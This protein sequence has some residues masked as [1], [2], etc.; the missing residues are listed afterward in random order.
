[1][2][3]SRKIEVNC[4]HCEAVGTYELHESINANLH[5]N[6]KDKLMNGDDL[7][8]YTCEKCGAKSMIEA[9][10]LYHDMDHKFMIWLMP[11]ADGIPNLQQL[12]GNE[13]LVDLTVDRGYRFRAVYG[14]T[15]LRDKIIQLESPY[16]DYALEWCKVI[17]GGLLM[18]Q[19]PINEDIHTSMYTIK[20]GDLMCIFPLK[21]R[22]EFATLSVKGN[23]MDELMKNC[24]LQE[25]TRGEIHRVNVDWAVE[26]SEKI[27]KNAN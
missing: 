9:P 19:A 17:Y 11:K 10:L 24:P 22:Q 21:D 12:L 16:P 25:P 20:D 26:E 3:L 5:P 23:Q 1:M 15:E 4:P 6:L 14:L 7:F 2:S 18:E 13:N 27:Q 8:Y